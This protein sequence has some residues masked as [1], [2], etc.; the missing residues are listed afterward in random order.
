MKHLLTAICNMFE[1]FSAGT[2]IGKILIVAGTILTAFYSPIALLLVACF[3]L[4]T[5]DL[6][7]G[8][9][10][11]RKFKKKLTSKKN[12]KGTLGKL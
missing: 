10:V 4:T 1:G 7:Y 11:A 9:K 5:T 12:W 3:I 2:T 8:L 6:I